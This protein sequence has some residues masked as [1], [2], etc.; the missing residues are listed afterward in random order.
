MPRVLV[1]DDDENLLLLAEKRLAK[2]MSGFNVIMASSAREALHN[3][4]KEKIDAIVSDYKMRGMDGLEFL[5]K[6]RSLGCDIPFIMFTGQGREEIA[7]DAL[8]LGAN[9]Y[10]KKEGKSNSLYRELA[11][12]LRQLVEH[13][14][15][16]Q[17]LQ[18][19]HARGQKYLDTASVIL[20]ALDRDGI[21]TMINRKGCAVLGHSEKEIVGKSWFETFLPERMQEETRAV[22]SKLME[23]EIEP[24]QSFENPIIPKNGNERLI[25]WQNT[26]LIE[27]GNIVGTLSSGDD[28]TERKQ[29]E[30]ALQESEERFRTIFQAIPNPAY[31]YQRMPNERIIL[32]DVNKAALAISQGQVAFCVNQDLDDLAA[33]SDEFS[34]SLQKHGVDLWQIAVNVRGVFASGKPLRVEKAFHLLSG[35]DKYFVLDYVPTSAETVVIVST[36]VTKRQ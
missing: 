28:I 3:L 35:E 12:I 24:A 36:D 22:F 9:Y 30:K 11:H 7:I 18:Q 5:R 4:A 8:N 33:L 1:V 29:A 25:A 27:K 21:V 14:K 23:G 10:L 15:T 17:N 20:V 32:V 26:V 6:I 19:A 2:A 34:P 31:L 16:E 13:R